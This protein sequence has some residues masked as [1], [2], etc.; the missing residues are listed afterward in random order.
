MEHGSTLL[1]DIV[2]YLAAAVVL[3]PLFI[4][5]KL[6]AVLGYLAAGILIGPAVLGLV[7]NAEQTLQFAEFGIVLLL[8]VIG[9]ELQPSR[10]WALRRDI[11]GLG[12]AQVLLCGLGL[13]GLLLALTSF[14]WEAALVVGLPLG[15]SSTALVMQLLNERQMAATPF[16]ERSFAMLLFQ[17]LAI[18]PM[19][20]IV[21]ALSRAPRPNPVPGW[22]TALMTAGALLFLVL[23]GRYALPRLFRII[24][25]LGAREAFVAAALLCVMGS[26]LLMASLG[27]SMAL[28]AFVAGVML[29]ESPYRHALEADIEPF[30]GLMLGLFFIAIGMSLDLGVVAANWGLVLALVVGV[31]AVKTTI[32]A[33]LARSFGTEWPRAFKMG[34][35]LAQGGEFGFVLFAE[36]ERGL[37]IS[38][39]AA[40]LFGAVVTCS[41]AL[42]PLL[43]RLAG[44]MIAGKDD[45]GSRDGPESAG[46]AGHGGHVVLVGSGRVGQVIAQMLRARGQAITA[47]DLDAELIDITARF[48][49]TVFWGDGTRLDIL[50]TA[51]IETASALVFAID[52]RWD[53]KAVLVPIQTEWPDL[54]IIARA[55]DRSH[56][57]ALRQAG[58]E[59]VVR[60]TLDG[61][62]AMGREVLTALGTPETMI[63]AIEAEYRRRDL[64]RL[65]LQLCSGDIMSGADTIIRGALDLDGAPDPASLGEIP[66][67]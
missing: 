14:T 30:R 21:G 65:D 20:T 2:V 18:V 66:P 56:N 44:R 32:I 39:S 11:F 27:L 51:G 29:A 25:S 24:G 63:D 47:I 10:L 26:A 62:V 28:G 3:V 52:G 23:V 8:F 6:G 12:L 46:T 22:Q 13:T 5:F 36:A 59:Q 41:M 19:L 61:A 15:L 33:V 48:G 53:P 64:E 7:G 49:N 42:T 38:H 35:L 1:R 54:P 57:I 67:A 34:L 45:P 17:D 43:F 40:Q 58:V 37:L 4:R 50:R 55:F 16:G 31:M 9:L 60:E